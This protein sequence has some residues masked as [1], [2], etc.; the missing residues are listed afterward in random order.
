[1]P[2]SNEK[3]S[4]YNHERT[5]TKYRKEQSHKY[6]SFKLLFGEA[7]KAFIRYCQVSIIVNYIKQNRDLMKQKEDEE[8]EQRAA[9][10]A[11][12]GEIR[13]QREKELA[14]LS[15]KYAAELRYVLCLAVF[16]MLVTLY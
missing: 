6:E 3:V 9:K 1:M 5:F 11:K 7:Q 4:I 13:R 15:A 12:E 2:L 14:K 8:T 10:K 16:V